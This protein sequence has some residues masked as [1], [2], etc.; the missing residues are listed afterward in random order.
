MEMFN[1]GGVRWDGRVTF[2]TYSLTKERSGQELEGVTFQTYSLTK[3]RSGQ[4]LEEALNNPCPKSAMVSG[5]V[6]DLEPVHF[7]RQPD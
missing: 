7:F 3:E 5:C 2:Q 6:P 4:E 1:E